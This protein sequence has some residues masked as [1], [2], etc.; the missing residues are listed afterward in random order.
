MYQTRSWLVSFPI[1]RRCGRRAADVVLGLDHH[2]HA[3]DE[4]HD[5]VDLD[6]RGIVQSRHGRGHVDGVVAVWHRVDAIDAKFKLTFDAE[7]A[8][9]GTRTSPRAAFLVSRDKGSACSGCSPLR[10]RPIYIK[11]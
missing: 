3:E 9:I 5:A 11:S 10:D 6:L 1:S 4:H 7:S 2:L 8:P